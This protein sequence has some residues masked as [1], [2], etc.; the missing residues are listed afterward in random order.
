[1]DVNKKNAHNFERF[2]FIP[3]CDVSLFAESNHGS[4]F[5]VVE[6]LAS[7]SLKMKKFQYSIQNILYFHLYGKHA[8]TQ[9]NYGPV[10]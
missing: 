2:N 1:M 9:L 5:F 10:E 6:V 4:Y 8:R 7:K 3:S